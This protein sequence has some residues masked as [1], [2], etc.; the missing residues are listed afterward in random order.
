MEWS[1]D[2]CSIACWVEINEADDDVGCCCCCCVL[3]LSLLMLLLLLLVIVVVSPSAL[4]DV[5]IPP[6]LLSISHGGCSNGGLT[7]SLQMDK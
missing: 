7:I 2:G 1:V 6:L 4:V 5:A 3:V